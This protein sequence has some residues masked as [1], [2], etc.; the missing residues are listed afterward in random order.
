MS[1]TS[2]LTLEHLRAL[3]TSLDEFRAEMRSFTNEQRLINQHIAPLVE[4]EL[5]TRGDLATLR[6]R[7][8]RIEQRLDLTDH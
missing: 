7:I 2:N 6:D 8:N 3:R 5:L 1:N 4:H